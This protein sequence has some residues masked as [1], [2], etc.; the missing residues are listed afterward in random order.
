MEASDLTATPQDVSNVKFM[1]F[2]LKADAPIVGK[3][4][5]N[6]RLR[7]DYSALL[8]SVERKWRHLSPALNLVFQP[9]DILWIVGNE[10]SLTALHE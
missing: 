4:L 9:A 6:S 2:T 8:V 10:A 5:G 1:H 3:S 7:E